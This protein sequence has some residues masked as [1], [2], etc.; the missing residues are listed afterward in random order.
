MPPRLYEVQIPLRIAVEANTR[1]EAESLIR[2]L[3][4]E[5]MLSLPV[6]AGCF[7]KDAT[8]DSYIRSTMRIA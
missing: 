4:H 5:V 1:H 7:L 2:K 8:L 6:G 3:H